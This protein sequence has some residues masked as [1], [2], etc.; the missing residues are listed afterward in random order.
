[1]QIYLK[2]SGGFAGR[3]VQVSLDT[4]SLP[5]A[6][7]EALKNLLQSAEFA[8]LPSENAEMTGGPGADQFTYELTIVDQATERTV[9]F[10]E[11]EAPAEIDQ[12][13]RQLMILARDN[14]MPDDSTGADP[15]AE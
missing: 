5:N 4:T 8:D 1:M 3:N 10:S 2:R 6:E 13:L 7:A 15:Q 9:C 12:F 14:N 11:S